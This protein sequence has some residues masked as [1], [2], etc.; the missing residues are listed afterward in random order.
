MSSLK[1]IEVNGQSITAEEIRTAATRKREEI[2]GNGRI[3]TP[4]ERLKIREEVIDS[5]VDRKLLLQEARRLSLTPSSEAIAT[6]ARNLF[7]RIESVTGCRAGDRA[8]LLLREVEEDLLVRNL[9]EHWSREVPRPK[10]SEARDFYRKNRELFWT[11]ELAWAAHIVKNTEGAVSAEKRADVEHLRQRVLG[12]EAF[13]EV[14]AKN[15]DCPE[16]GGDL[17]YFRRGTMV[18]EFDD[19]IFSA[20]VNTLTAVFQTRFGYHIAIVYDRKPEG[21]PVLSEIQPEV[22]RLLYLQKK[23]REIGRRLAALRNRAVIKYT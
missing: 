15:S 4:N 14:A 13:S 6:A 17:G 9:V 11:G 7:P 3:L 18:E 8:E 21:I 1:L 20:P 23:D 2:E 19:I 12:G 5:L 10:P 22:E 16:N